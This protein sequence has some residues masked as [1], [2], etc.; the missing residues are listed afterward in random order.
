MIQIIILD[1]DGVI[2]ESVEVKSEAFRKLFSFAPEYVAAIVQF[3]RENGGMSR[4]DK[5]NYIYKNILKQELTS[6]GFQE[7]S[8]N[9]S[10]L[11]FHEVITA[12]YVSGA[13]EFLE[14]FHT[15]I[16]LYVVSATPEDELIAI[17]RE[18]E[19][20]RYFRKIYGSPR[21]KTDCI[22]EIL[23]SNNA[24]PLSV[25]FVGDA[26]NDWDAAKAAHVRFVGRNGPEDTGQFTGCSG[27]EKVIADL[28]E[29]GRYIE[30]NQ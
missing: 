13:Y 5:I 9:F 19:L 16:P 6:S 11:V 4:F 2:L 10:E 18:K 30:E 20:T 7:L 29:L 27:I 26:R 24:P 21:K 25:I 23:A 28:H 15:K 22:H 12:P 3:H 17:V 1:F 14:K 8:D